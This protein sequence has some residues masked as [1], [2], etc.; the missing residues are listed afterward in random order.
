MCIPWIEDE[1]LTS[2]YNYLQPLCGILEEYYV[3]IWIVRSLYS[4]FMCRSI[5]HNLTSLDHVLDVGIM[6]MCLILSLFPRNSGVSADICIYIFSVDLILYRV[7][8][9]VIGVAP[10]DRVGFLRRLFHVCN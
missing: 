4:H 7:V 1:I 5:G 9:D 10:F 8:L 6:L 3:L 2:F